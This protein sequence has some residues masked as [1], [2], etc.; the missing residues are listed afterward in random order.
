LPPPLSAWTRKRDFP[1]FAAKSFH[2]L[3]EEGEHTN[4]QKV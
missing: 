2:E 3:W 1:V 4:A